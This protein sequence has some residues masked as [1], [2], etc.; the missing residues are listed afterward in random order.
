MAATASDKVH[1]SNVSASQ[2][3]GTTKSHL[4]IRKHKTKCD[5][6]TMQ[7]TTTT[8]VS[9]PSTSRQIMP[10]DS[11][12]MANKQH[13]DENNNKLRQRYMDIDATVIT[14]ART[15]DNVEQ[16]QTGIELKTMDPLM[17]PRHV[18][19]TDAN[20]DVLAEGEIKQQHCGCIQIPIEHA[21]FV[22]DKRKAHDVSSLKKTKKKNTHTQKL[23]VCRFPV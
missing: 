13:N 23:P 19:R 14:S 10:I 7:T 17:L 3:S 20:R 2:T 1:S 16:H 6:M 21:E 22:E 15:S 5:A 12:Q 18:Q 4:S 11:T 8:N 9:E